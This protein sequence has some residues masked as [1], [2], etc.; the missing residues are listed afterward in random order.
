[1]KKLVMAT[2]ATA[3]LGFASN[4]FA[5]DC[6][7]TPSSGASTQ[8]CSTTVSLTIDPQVAVGSLATTLPLT[9]SVTGSSGSLTFCLGTNSGTGVTVDA[10]ST[11]T[12]SA[13]T[14]QMDGTLDYTATINTVDLVESGTSATITTG[15]TLADCVGGGAGTASLDVAT[16]Q[17]AQDAVSAGSYDDVLV[18][19]VT[20]L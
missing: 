12:S 11:D 5:Q 3:A 2:V 9:Y 14:F 6:S 7:G 8:D 1:M 18:L 13:G 20:P 19:T 17:S 4:G 15:D 10:T 16:S